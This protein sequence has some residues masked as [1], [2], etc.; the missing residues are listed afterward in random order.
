MYVGKS[1]DEN[2]QI[3][4][5]EMLYF[6]DKVIPYL[7]AIYN[8]SPRLGNAIGWVAQCE[9]ELMRRLRPIQTMKEW[10]ALVY[11]AP[12]AVYLA[13]RHLFE[14]PLVWHHDIVGE[15][16][17]ETLKPIFN[18][19]NLP[20]QLI[21]NS[22]RCKLRDSQANTFLSNAAMRDVQATPMTNETRQR[23]ATIAAV[24]DVP[25]ETFF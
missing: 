2:M 16:T 12:Y 25:V 20:M 14:L 23:L 22:L 15:H 4:F 8:Y 5:Y 10:A 24:I 11:A 18:I 17:A 7:L 6:S 19:L 1:F 13:H 9:G 21:E 3:L